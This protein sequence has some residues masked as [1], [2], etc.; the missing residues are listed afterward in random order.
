MDIPFYTLFFTDFFVDFT[1]C[2][3][4]LLISMYLHFILC[5]C[6][7]CHKTKQN[8]KVKSKIKIKQI[9]KLKP[10]ANKRTRT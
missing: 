6:Y 2:I 10:K 9:S 1:L 5:P 4:N 8:F 7:A 3:P